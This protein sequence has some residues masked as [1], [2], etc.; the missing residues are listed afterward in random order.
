MQRQSS[1]MIV[2]TPSSDKRALHL[3]IVS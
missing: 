1:D 2:L 3:H